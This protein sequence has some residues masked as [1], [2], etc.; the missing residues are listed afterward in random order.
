MVLGPGSWYTSVLPHLILPAM[1]QALVNTSARK[2]VV[3]N[4][5]AQQGGA[6]ENYERWRASGFFNESIVT[7]HC[8]PY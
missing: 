8:D 3:L 5:S 4:L 1:R 2:V 7:I 6:A